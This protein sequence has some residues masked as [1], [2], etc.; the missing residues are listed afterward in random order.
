MLRRLEADDLLN[1]SRFVEQYVQSRTAKGFGPQKIRH[2]L[3][4][5]GIDDAL[6]DRAI[7]DW[8]GDWDRLLRIVFH[9]KYSEFQRDAVVEIA[10]P[11]RFLLQRGFTGDQIERLLRDLEFPAEP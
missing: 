5:R 7:R 4:E 3:A 11:A 2:E 1:S 9:K 10:R 6:I 8:S